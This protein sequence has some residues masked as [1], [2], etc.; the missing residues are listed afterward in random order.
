MSGSGRCE[1]GGVSYVVDGDLR[2]VW[3]C[4]CGP[5]R[6][7]T[8]HHMAATAAPVADVEFTSTETLTW[9]ERVEGV[10]YGFCNRCGSTLFWRSAD[11]AAHLSICAGTLD[12]PTGLDTD[13]ILFAAEAGDYHQLEPGIPTWNLDR[14]SQRTDG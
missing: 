14:H 8:G 13:G 9:Y 10:E 1:C 6:R 5:C 2:N 4:H 11:K 3:N 7:I 12:Q